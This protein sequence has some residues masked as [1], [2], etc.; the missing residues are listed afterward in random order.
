MRAL[1][2]FLAFTTLLSSRA[3]ADFVNY[4]VVRHNDHTVPLD[5]D[6]LSVYNISVKNIKQGDSLFIEY[7][8][9]NPCTNCVSIVKLVPVREKLDKSNA[10]FYG[11]GIGH[12]TAGIDLNEFR[13][14]LGE[15]TLF[16]LYYYEQGVI[17]DTAAQR[18]CRLRMWP[19]NDDKRQTAPRFHIELNGSLIPY[20]KGVLPIVYL[21]AK[22][23]EQD[24]DSISIIY[25]DCNS[26]EDCKQYAYIVPQ[27]SK[28]TMKG[29]IVQ[30]AGS[31]TK[32]GGGIQS[33]DYNW[34]DPPKIDLKSLIESATPNRSY[35][36]FYHEVGKTAS[37]N[38]QLVMRI[39]L[40]EASR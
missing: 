38:Q 28:Q 32:Y 30:G 22:L 9:D 21:D 12:Q 15:D 10:A 39:F 13:L 7:H 33:R 36:V 27:G 14:Y 23:K 1:I 8:D 11:F 26:C 20:E 34:G 25:N 18:I 35:D 40:Q 37:K 2:L 5:R 4:F 29:A 19:C 24:R 31:N 3:N 6:T 17:A 16:D